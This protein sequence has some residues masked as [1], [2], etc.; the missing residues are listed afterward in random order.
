[1]AMGCEYVFIVSNKWI[2]S[3]NVA[4]QLSTSI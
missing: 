3:A 1:M 2:A 4:C